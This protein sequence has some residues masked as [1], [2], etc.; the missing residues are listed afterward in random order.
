MN[1]YILIEMLKDDPTIL[2]DVPAFLERINRKDQTRTVRKHVEVV[3]EEVLFSM[4]EYHG[5][6]C[7]EEE[8][9]RAAKALDAEPLHEKARQQFE[10]VA[11]AITSGDVK[12]TTELSAK[13]QDAAA[14][15]SNLAEK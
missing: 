10:A 12:D 1:Q 11:S 4:A 15:V 6:E 14:E 3:D 8:V 5:G 13:F 2:D 7:T 9:Q